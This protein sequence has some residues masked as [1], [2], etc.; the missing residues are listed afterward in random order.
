[1]SPYQPISIPSNFAAIGRQRLSPV[2]GMRLFAFR[3]AVVRTRA[4]TLR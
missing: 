3:A 1:M 4:A 2:Q